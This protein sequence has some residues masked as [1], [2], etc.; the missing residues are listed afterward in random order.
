M[1]E[2]FTADWLALREPY[3][4]SARS[5]ALLGRLQAWREGRDGLRVLD[6]GA[7]TGANLRFLAPRLGGSQS[8]TLVELDAAL[9]RQ[10]EQRLAGTDV[11]W[12]YR[13][14]DLAAGLGPFQAAS[15]DLLTA[16]ALLDLVSEA[17]LEEPARLAEV[18]SAALYVT[19]T[20]D[21]RIAW[22]PMS[23][24]DAIVTSLVNEHQGT[25]KGFGPALGPQAVL[26]LRRALAGIPGELL[27]ETSDW[28]LTPDDR[29]I[30]A[31]L[32]DGYHAAAIA[33]APD[34]A[35]DITAWTSWRRRMIEAGES[36]LTVGHLD[37]LFLPA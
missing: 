11:D 35:D 20:Y 10:G 31:A 13:R 36:G 37:A 14:H 19:L 16:S 7:G 8:W 27:I 34:Q 28:R 18:S 30:Q 32:L 21:G 29:A 25:D 22:E 12:V 23:E 17:W 2:A 9:I 15:P 33:M 5:P 6:L 1:R 24:A 26:A 3:D 4:A